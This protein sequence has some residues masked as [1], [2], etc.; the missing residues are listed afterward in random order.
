MNDWWE[1]ES[2]GDNPRPNIH[3]LQAK[4]IAVLRSYLNE[5]RLVRRGVVVKADPITR[6]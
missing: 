1:N 6:R 5:D 2:S 4:D 3:P